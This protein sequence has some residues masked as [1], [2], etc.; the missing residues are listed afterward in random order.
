LA[1]KKQKEIE[2]SESNGVMDINDQN[3]D[4]II[5]EGVTIVDF[6][7]PWCLPCRLQG[8]ILKNVSGKVGDKAKICKMNVDENMTTAQKY[9]I[10]SI[11]TLLVFRDGEI[12]KKFIG[13]QDE[14]TLINAV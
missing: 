12:D 2:M 11:P 10:V 9:G 4:Q 6:W 7:A 5:S 13:V 3:F 1:T 14:Q 8:P